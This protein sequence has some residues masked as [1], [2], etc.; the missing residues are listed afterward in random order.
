MTLR[1]SF[2][3]CWPRS[4]GMAFGAL[5]RRNRWFTVGEIIFWDVIVLIL[6]QLMWLRWF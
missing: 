5:N 6:I 2:R 4:S 3:C 1:V